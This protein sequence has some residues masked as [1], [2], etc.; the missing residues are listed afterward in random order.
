MTRFRRT[1]AT[2]L[3][4]VLT[5]AAAGMLAQAQAFDIRPGQWEMTISGF[6]VPPAAL[7]KMP[8]AARQQFVAEMA[9]PH[10]STTCISASDLKD[11]NIGKLDD[12]EECKVTSRT[13]TRTSA[14]FTRQCT[15]DDKRT[16]T[17]HIEAA[18]PTSFKASIRS[19]TT[20]GTTTMGMTARWLAAACKDEDQ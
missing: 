10:T 2:T 17:M 5:A 18:S 16:D 14:D 11:L 8:A 7:E 13:L 1:L 12:D 9:K 6:T 19:T 15:G 3:A 20:D 4:C